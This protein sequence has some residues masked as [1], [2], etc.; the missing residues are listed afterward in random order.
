M[1]VDLLS[2]L[3]MSVTCKRANHPSANYALFPLVPLQYCGCATVMCQYHA[4]MPLPPNKLSVTECVPVSSDHACV[5]NPHSLQCML[6][7]HD[8]IMHADHVS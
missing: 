1:P 5:L 6:T 7:M 4:L 8:D 3:T 2:N